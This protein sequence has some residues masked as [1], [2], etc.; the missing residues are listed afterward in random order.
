MPVIGGRPSSDLAEFSVSMTGPQGP[1]GPPGAQGIPGPGGP[2][3]PQGTN[4]SNGTDGAPGSTG[5]QGSPG[6][7]G[8]GGAPGATGP[9]GLQGP[10]GST[11]P[12]GPA[13]PTGPQGPIGTGGPA[14]GIEY[15][16]TGN[17]AAVNVQAAITELD[18]EK[19]AKAGDTMTGPLVLTAAQAE[20]YL[21][22]PTPTVGGGVIHH[23]NG[24]V[25]TFDISMGWADS[26]KTF[27]SVDRYTDAGVFQDSPFIIDKTTGLI[28]IFGPPV[29]GAHA[30]NKAYVDSV[31]GTGGGGGG[32]PEAPNDGLQYARKSL[33][34]AEVTQQV[35]GGSFNY[36]FNA[37]TSPPAAAGSVRF[38]NVSQNLATI[39]HINYTTNDSIAVNNKTFFTSRVKV[40]DTFYFQDKDQVDKWKLYRLTSAFTDN[41]TYASMPV[42]FVAGGTD[43]SAARIIVSREGASVA[44]PI[45][46]API[47]GEIY[48][49]RDALWTPLWD[50]FLM[51][52]GSVPM[53]GDLV[54]S[55]AQP[56]ITLNDT[57]TSGGVG[58]RIDGKR[59]GS[60]RWRMQLGD[61]VTEGGLNTGS[62]FTL[63]AYTDA[64]AAGP[65]AITIGRNDGLL[66]VAANPTAPL[67]VATKQYADTKA[68]KATVST[69][70]PSG[71][72]DG[73]VW[74]QVAP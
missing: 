67:G 25:A 20:I 72:V 10:P 69:S 58:R 73:D 60:M 24:G 40:G 6:P 61:G 28:E 8:P 42:E 50:D 43:L 23:F 16:P 56:A 32:V 54:L 35:Y 38:N 1:P 13:G 22:Q 59:L 33:A 27:F 47:D 37:G 55:Y 49:R 71:G 7:Q 39:I 3:G 46:E 31:A 34:W 44:S 62:Q 51:L 18:N 14:S 2:Q 30:A 15:T 21:Q 45:G 17:V 70:A 36:L 26:G 5:P 66:K 4:G 41:G 11:G 52:D 29:I 48:A 63:T 19:V 64:G 68:T 57:L 74:Y 65:V 12:A 53:T 9:Q